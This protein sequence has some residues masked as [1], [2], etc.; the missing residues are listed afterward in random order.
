VA[1]VV[2]LDAN[3]RRLVAQGLKRIRSGHMQAG[4]AALFAAA[5]RDPTQATAQDFGF[6]LGPRINAAGRL[7]DMTLGIEC[8]TTDD[9]NRAA[10]LAQALEAINRERRSV[11]DH[12]L[13]QAE[14]LLAEVAASEAPL[15]A[16]F[17]T[18][19]QNTPQEPHAPRP[20]LGLEHTPEHAPSAVALFHPKFHEGV[21][22]ILAGRLKEQLHRPVIVFARGQDGLL[23]GSG[24]SIEGF[25]LRDALDLISKR[26]PQALVRF[27]GHA[28]AA[29]CTLQPAALERFSAALQQVALEWL[30]EA[31]LQRRL[32]IDG[33]LPPECYSPEVAQ[34][35]SSQV[36]GQG[37]EPPLF[38][39]R[40][41]VLH[42]RLVGQK[43]LKLSVRPAHDDRAAPRDAI[44]FQRTEPVVDELNLAYRI[45]VNEWQGR[46]AAQ[47]VVVAQA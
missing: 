25:H 37:F 39:E 16:D 1:D 14:R 13:E 41:Q 17:S 45:E 34:L 2:K 46:V 11:E 9:P 40:M 21:V 35:L 33:P 23:K 28:M 22:G 7:S 8:L 24:R 19:Q 30:D 42:Q 43:H 31:T 27:G 36:W 15:R 5:G 10:E 12:M 3:N 29:G 44:W 18:L 32:R 38:C 6:A 20:T 47:M 26:E 4:V